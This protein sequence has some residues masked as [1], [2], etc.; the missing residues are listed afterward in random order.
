[1]QCTFRHFVLVT[2]TLNIQKI[3][4]LVGTNKIDLTGFLFVCLFVCLSTDI[5]VLRESSESEA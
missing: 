2:L 1:M 3:F 4:D 5:E